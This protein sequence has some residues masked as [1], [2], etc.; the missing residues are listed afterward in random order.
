MVMLDVGKMLCDL[1]VNVADVIILARLGSEVSEDVSED[2]DEF[3]D[4]DDGL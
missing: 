3:L 1:D 4:G 2:V